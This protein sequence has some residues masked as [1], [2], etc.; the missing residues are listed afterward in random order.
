VFIQVVICAPR[1]ARFLGISVA[2]RGSK[3]P[4]LTNIPYQQGWMLP[5]ACLLH[6]LSLAAISLQVE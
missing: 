5:V 2:L 3:L 4:L 6:F 1:S